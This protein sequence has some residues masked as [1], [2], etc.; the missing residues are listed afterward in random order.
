MTG[1]ILR[2]NKRGFSLVELLVA[3]AITT[4]GLLGLLQGIN[5]ALESN[6]KNLYRVEASSVGEEVLA[7]AKGMPFASISTPGTGTT[8][9]PRKIRAVFRN[10]SVTRQVVT[11]SDKTKQIQVGVVWH[12]KG[13]R[14][15][16]NV[17]TMVSRETFQ[18]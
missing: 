11:I 17:T 9:V 13:G 16:Q 6:A 1:R 15:E 10:F 3:M 14:Y 4:I 12:Y 7:R 18:P 5:L 8:F 2:L